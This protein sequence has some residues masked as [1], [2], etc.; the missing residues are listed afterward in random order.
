MSNLPIR[1]IPNE[2]ASPNLILW[3]SAGLALSLAPHFLHLPIWITAIVLAALG[4]RSMQALKGWP[5]LPRW[6]LVIFVILGGIAVF[7][8]F[9]TVAGRDAGVALLV[10]MTS[11]KSLEG[12][13]LR[14]ML[15]LVILSYFLLATH[16]L[17]S[18]SI[19]T[20]AFMLLATVFI[21]S[22][23]IVMNQR[24]ARISLPKRLQ[25]GGRML[26]MAVP[27][28]ILLFVLV[29]RINGPLWGFS[30][31]QQGGITGLDDKMTPGTIS[32]LIADNQVAFRVDFDGPIPSPG[33]L[34]WRGP[35]MSAFTGQTW[36]L[37]PRRPKNHIVVRSLSPATR[38]SI[39]LEPHGKRWLFALDMPSETV[40]KSFFTADLQLMSARPVNELRRYELGSFLQYRVGEEEDPAYL[41][42]TRDFPLH[43]NPQ[44][45]AFGHQLAQQYQ[46]PE[47]IINAA[48][49]FYREQEFFYTITPPL[50][51]QINP[52]DD[53]LFNSRQGFCEH[54]AGSF[55]LLMRAAGL[56][57][58]VVTGYQGGEINEV[59]NYL[60]VRQSDAHAWSEVWIEGKGWVRVDPTAAVAPNRIL[61]GLDDAL[62]QGSGSGFRIEKKNPLLGRIMFSWDNIQRSWN[63][64]VVDYN[65][66]KQRQLMQQLGIGDSA[67]SMVLLL[68]L[69]LITVSISYLAWGWWQQRPAPK[70]ELEQILMPLFKRLQR[71][72]Q[73]RKASETLPEFIHRIAHSEPNRDLLQQI[74]ALYHRLKYAGTAVNTDDLQQLR[75]L[76]QR[77]RQSPKTG[78]KHAPIR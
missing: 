74:A 31:D 33:A 5:A 13:N 58:R 14:D 54:Y 32:S 53:F 23:L 77:Y 9:Y 50:L 70:P 30:N 26:L 3:S 73:M 67:S 49:K 64:W 24:E 15:I 18:Q 40:E 11:L 52:M 6:L 37:L 39:T 71:Q 47:Q 38:Y 63:N 29:P 21:T 76:I 10:V 42:L 44:T 69:S 66:L 62:S 43:V 60:I 36:R 1:Q 28:M 7:S 19:G 8:R 16:F 20:A 22:T 75:E 35:V 46:T 72:G 57:A 41:K 12:R 51:E 25:M 59:G 2:T 78:P 68:V 55:T 48:L 61:S 4:W 45:L 17:Y 56:S 34:Y 27:M 65:E